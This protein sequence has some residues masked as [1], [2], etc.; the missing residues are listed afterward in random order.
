[1]EKQKRWHFFLILAVIALTIYNIFPT[2]FY[3]SRP[4]KEPISAS[5][6]KEIAAKIAARTNE[7]ETDAI[8]F[9]RSFS[10]LLGIKPASVT[11]DQADREF[12]TI[13]FVKAADAERFQSYFP[14]A[15]ALIPFAPSRLRLVEKTNAN[16]DGK[17][18]IIKREFGAKLQE[19]DFQFA[20]SG[21]D[22]YKKILLERSADVAETLAGPSK[23]ALLLD[24]IEKN[25]PSAVPLEWLDAVASQILLLA[26]I[27][28]SAPLYK[29]FA[30][31]LTRGSSADKAKS[32]ETLIAAFEHGKTE[33]A[34]RKQGSSGDLEPL[35][36]KKKAAFADALKLL[37]ANPSLFYQRLPA[38]KGKEIEKQL[39]VTSHFFLG[40]LNPF[41]SDLSIDWENQKIELT[42]HADL[43]TQSYAKQLIINELAALNFLTNETFERGGNGYFAKFHE[44]DGTS[45]LLVVDKASL[46]K[47]QIQQLVSWL[48]DH[49]NP[50]HPDLSSENL[51]IV[52]LETY[53]SL[54]PE[55]KSLCLVF[56]APAAS[57]EERAELHSDSIYCFAKGFGRIAQKYEK[58]PHSELAKQFHADEIALQ[59]LLQQRGFTAYLG[60]GSALLEDLPCDIVFEERRFLSPMLSATREEFTARG[61]TG[62]SVIELSNVEQRIFKENQIETAIHEDLVKSSDEYQTSHVNPDPLFRYSA[63]RPAKNVF[64]HNLQLSFRKMLRGD[65]KKVIRWGLD[66]SG[67]KTLQIELKDANNQIVTDD[68]QIKQGINELYN[69]VNKMGVSEVSIR[70]VGHQIA[71]DFPGSQALSGSDLVRASTMYFHVVNEKFSLQNIDL[72][73]SVNRFLQEVWNEA[74]VTRKTD[75]KSINEI[76]FEHLYGGNSEKPAPRSGAAKILLDH[77]LKLAHPDSAVCSSAV[78][79]TLSKLAIYREDFHGQT[80]PLLIVFNNYALEGSH[81]EQIR[82]AYDPSKG[83]FLSFEVQKSAKDRWNHSVSP[84]ENLHAWTSLFSKPKVAGTSLESYSRGNGWRMATILNDSVVTCPTLNDALRDSAAI[85]GAFSPREVSQLASDLKAGSL[86]FTPHI[87]SEK[88]VSPELGKADRTKGIVATFV[89]L[90]LVIVS[91]VVYYRFAGLIASIA[92]FF[93]ILIMWAILQNLGATMSLAGIAGL[94]LTVGM[95]VDA[96]V[97]VFERIK[98]EFA[99]HA[100]IAAAIKAGYKKAFSAIVDSNVTTIIAALILLNFDAGPIKAF[101]TTLIIGIASSMFTALFMTRF[102]FTIWAQKETSKSLSMANWIKASRFDF[103]KWAKF[104]FALAAALCI[105]GT[106]TAVQNRS[107]LL[108]MDFTGGFSLHLELSPDAHGSYAARVEKA[109]LSHGLS[110]QDFQVREQSPTHHLRLLLSTALEQPG[111]TFANMPLELDL[112]NSTHLFE[113]NPRIQW[114]VSSLEADGLKISPAS[115][116]QLH[117]N[118]ATMSGQMSDSMRT[119]AA[120]GLLIAF[121]CIF[122]YITFRFEYKF[123]AAAILCLLHDVLIT[124]SLLGILHF[125]GVPVQI[126]LN[127]IAAL[128]TII[129]YSLND[130]IIVFDRIREDMQYKS[131]RNL[132]SIVNHALNATLSRTSITSGTTLLVLIALVCLGGAS[133]FSFAL[134]MLIGV[135]FGTLSSWFIAAP[136]MLYFHKKEIESPETQTV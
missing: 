59:K 22:L 96:N 2:I 16:D 14:R 102:Y 55:K 53:R 72:R 54:N 3:Y 30:A 37:K 50:A 47:K 1:M 18:V 58:F 64:W 44:L 117:T 38:P 135:I 132:S 110:A 23:T 66:L 7:L 124:I 129:G 119:Q 90:I 63:P 49:W 131:T 46:A 48:R 128:M 136:L 123:A 134:V 77:G 60:D 107:T 82:A 115:L 88:N 8:D 5:M 28:E 91:M 79:Q 109:L 24:S 56:F 100:S 65:E 133:I 34:K 42:L 112:P 32:I 75:A 12:L 71:I 45:A 15:G 10:D 93:N 114:L 116:S 26:D 11:F 76:A 31:S 41:F 20:E 9:A 70:Q 40:D 85:S 52:D 51:S 80:H 61:L 35:L 87:L 94:I 99:G 84:S 36:E 98:E 27:P 83:H 113:K 69:R 4:L 121:A 6:G 126:D 104:S 97:L 103:L 118:W 25:G 105:I 127:T 13:R 39:A 92:V 62:Q 95:A 122:V 108:G 81:V 73:E 68:A 74:Q 101:A 29:R 86:T 106:F 33:L 43:E 17:T 57:N 21:S 78:D 111:K 125:F 120:I 19:S 130:T 89:A 67:G